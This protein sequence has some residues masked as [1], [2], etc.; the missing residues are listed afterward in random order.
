MIELSL[1]QVADA[2]GGRLHGADPTA[3]LHRPAVLDSRLAEPGSL[4]VAVRGEH[5]DGHDFAA[6]AVDAGAVAVLA[7]RPV[8]APAVVVPDTV[9][10]LGRLATRVRHRLPG[11]RVVALTGSQ[12]KTSTKD[13][14]A[15]LLAG[16]GPVVAPVGSYNNELGVPL[17]VL[18]A[19]PATAHF[20][21]EMGAR[22]DGQISYLCD[23]A[24][25]AVG[26]VLNV[27]TAHLGEFGSREAIAQAKGELVEALPDS[28]LAV[29]N[30]DDHLVRQMAAL[31][32][33]RV[34]TFGT[35]LRADV[36]AEDVALDDQGRPRFTLVSPQGK[37]PV[38]M[39][40]LGAH[41]AVN[42][43]AAAAVALGAGVP[44]AEVASGLEAA[45]PVSPWRMERHVRTDGVIVINDAYNASP[46]AM[47]S[48]LH[49]LAAMGGGA[50]GRRTV[51][52]LG[53]MRELGD[54]SASEHDAIGRL[55]ARL[56]V[57]LLVVVGEDA[58][59]LLQG[60]RG[61]ESWRGESVQVGDADTAV[62]YVRD[63]L[64][65]GDVVLVKAARA[66]GL[67]RVAA[68]LV[69]DPVR[70]RAGG[71]RDTA[72]GGR[73]EHEDDQVGDPGGNPEGTSGR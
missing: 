39:E 19:D 60:A 8:D 13:L 41:Q 28:G 33:A 73:H 30:A 2:V 17:T 4:F 37:T 24:Q 9:A 20:V 36:R 66:A 67:E 22:G 6:S 51:A 49:T 53:E 56:G 58:T 18:H 43:A 68:A 65:G 26:V 14:L 10:A 61:E 46:D 57:D 69:S 15:R 55:A 1:Q 47:R 52:V 11:T 25:P 40:L 48:A 32:Q 5:V 12:G 54:T 63:Q 70:A 42:A 34:L 44:L 21:V 3:V 62:A 31:T 16:L 23:I 38:V 71:H 29:L 64:R 27:G 59:G 7:S 35:T 50:G 72:R 45:R